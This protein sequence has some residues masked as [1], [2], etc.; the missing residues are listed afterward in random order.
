M[1]LTFP[2][3]ALLLFVSLVSAQTDSPTRDPFPPIEARAGIVKVHF[4]EFATLPTMA[5]QPQP[6]RMMLLLNEPGTKRLFVNDM[7]GLLYTL[8]YDGKKRTP[9]LD[10]NAAEWGYPVQSQGGERGFQSF[11]IHPQF[12]EAGSRGYGKFY[13][14]SDTTSMTAKADFTMPAEQHTHD[15]VLLEWTA[16]TPS[17]AS[18]DGGRPKEL[19]RWAQPY[20]NHNAGHVTFNPLASPGDSDFGL[21]YLGAADGGSGGDPFHVGQNLKSGFGKILR[22]DPLGSNSANGKYGIPANNPFVAKGSNN[23][24]GEIYA[25]G[26]RNTQRLFWDS[27]THAMFMSEIG[28]NAIEE[29]SPVTAG[30][31]LGWNRWEGS[32]R[33]HSRAGVLMG[34]SRTDNGITYPVVEYD[35][36]DPL[37]LNN[38]AAIGGFVYRH[39]AIPQLTGKLIF[40]DN[41][42]GE[43]FYV[44]ADNLPQGGSHPIRRVL[45]DDKGTAKTLL[46]LIKEK[47]A[48]QGLK[49]ANRA[50][51]RFGEG[52]DGK[53]F[54]LNKRDGTIRMLVPSSHN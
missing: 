41:P 45:F 24:L 23:A 14:Y 52:P 11:A 54:I 21:L 3:V 15:T 44:S 47:N 35:H 39:T 19:L 53:I 9:Y 18:Y 5:G 30:A 42:S 16:K 48:A 31:N 38:V 27:K 36:S 1:K 50:D 25:Y 13:T 40:G 12:N 26:I 34:E 37:L 10:L 7:V 46:Q 29:I 20:G 43:I 2:C 32:L 17:A 6:A 4:V 8:S 22:I 28:Q 51:L 33:F 49:P